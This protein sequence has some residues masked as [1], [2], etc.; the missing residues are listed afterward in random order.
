MGGALH[1]ATRVFRMY[2]ID[3]RVDRVLTK[4]KPSVSPRF[5]AD[6]QNLQPNDAESK[7]NIC[8]FCTY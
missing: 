8:H 3:N 6:Q 7:T 4:E 2:N 1:R 5:P